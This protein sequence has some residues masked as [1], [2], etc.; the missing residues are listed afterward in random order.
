MQLKKSELK[1]LL[2]E[3]CVQLFGCNLSEASEKQAYKSVCT[4]LRS[5]LTKE[6][7]NFRDE[8]AKKE[9]KE[10]YYM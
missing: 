6:N 1:T 10:V 4:V 3:T 7:K 8:V 5:I 2:N 9:Q